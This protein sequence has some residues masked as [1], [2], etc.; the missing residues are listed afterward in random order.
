MNRGRMV[1]TL[2][3]G[4][5]LAVGTSTGL[6]AQQPPQ[7]DRGGRQRGGQRFDRARMQEM[8]MERIKATLNPSEDEWT[9]IKPRLEKVMTLSMESRMGGM[10]AGRGRPGRPGGDAPRDANDASARETSAMEKAS[11]ALRTTLENEKA[12]SDDIKARLLALR[13]A[14]EKSREELAQARESLR[15]LLTQ[16]QEAQLVLMGL[17]D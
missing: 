12:T 14:R 6:W 4:A 8:F 5:L 2:A 11:E 17:M 3:L 15:E 16:R 10:R 9:V 13:E 1:V 7:Q